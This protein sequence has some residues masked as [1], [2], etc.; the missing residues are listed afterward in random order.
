MKRAQT[1]DT[2]GAHLACALA[3]AR[4]V[5]IHANSLS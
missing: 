1:S 5:D 2:V 3:P 4:F